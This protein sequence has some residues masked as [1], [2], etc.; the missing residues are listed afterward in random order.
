MDMSKMTI[1]EK[2]AYWLKNPW[3]LANRPF[4]VMENIYFVGTNWVSMF[5]LDTKEGLVLIDCAMQETLYLLVD[6][7][8][9]LGFDPHNIKKI[10]LTHG[11]FDHC[12]AV[13]AIQEMSGC[14]VWIGKDEE[15]FFTERRDLIVCEDT[16]PEF[17]ITNFYDYDSVIDL[18][19]IKIQPVHCPGHTPGTTS[20]FFDVEH[21]GKNLTCAI[22]GGL[23]AGV[24]T[25]KQLDKSGQP[26]S[27]REEYLESIAKVFD[28]KVDVVLPSHAGHCVDHDFLKIGAEDDGTGNG[29]INPEEW[30]KMLTSK[31][32]QI[33]QM[34]RDN[35]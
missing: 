13:R 28:R 23:G 8:R 19:D 34:I 33:E 11:H 4:K 31:K 30:K 21:E 3:T 26:L 16:V 6:N 2:T 14:E 27:M 17:E 7:I 18:G 5:L 20:L 10:L 12:G 15:F 35:V 25:K 29:F 22:H 32:L 9:A 1:E 24:L